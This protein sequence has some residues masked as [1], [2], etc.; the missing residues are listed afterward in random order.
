[1]KVKNGILGSLLAITMV[2]AMA[3]I[4]S[5]MPLLGAEAAYADDIPAIDTTVTENWVGTLEIN[6][7]GTYKFCGITH[8]NTNTDFDSAIHITDGAE[9]N[10]VFEGENHLT[11]N[12]S[13]P[14]LG[15]AGIQVDN[16]STVHIYGLDGS[17]LTVAGGG[18]GAG[19]GG[20]GYSHPGT[21]D[22]NKEPGKI[23]IHSGTITAIGG[24]KGAGI[25]SG[26]HSSGGDITILGGDIT[27]LG[28]G[29]GA[30][31]G[32]G[33]GTSGGDAT[34]AGAG[35]YN[36]GNITISGGKVRAAA[37]HM[38]FENFDRNDPETMYGAA[39]ADTFAA[40]I[41]G[42]YG[43]S[44]GTITI[45][46]NANVIALGSCGG[47]GIGT[48]RGTPKYVNFDAQHASCSVTIGGNAKVVA[49]ATADRRSGVVGDTGGAAIGLGRGVGIAG[50]PV[51]TIT[52]EGNADVYAYAAAGANGIGSSCAV[53]DF[54]KDP[55]SGEIVY[56]AN[57]SVAG[58]TIGPNTTVV[59]ICGS[60]KPAREAFDESVDPADLSL[61]ALH[62]DKTFFETAS[63]KD[64]VPFFQEDVF[65]ATINVCSTGS[66][67]VLTTIN[68]ESPIPTR[69]D[70]HIK[71]ADAAKSYYRIRDYQSD[72]G[73]NILLAKSLSA[74]GWK[75]GVGENDVTGLML[76]KYKIKYKLNGGKNSAS[77]PTQYSVL[78]S[79]V[80]LADPKRTYYKFGG[81]YDNKELTGS[82]VT[83]LP[84]GDIGDKQ[85]WAKWI[86]EG[87]L[88]TAKMTAKD[89]KNMTLEWSKTEGAEGYDIFFAR[90]KKNGKE[91]AFKKIKTIEGNKTFTLNKGDLKSGVSYKMYVKAFV[92]ENG[93]K[94]Y[95]YESPHMHAYA[96]GGTK[97]YTNAASVNVNKTKVKIKKGKTFKLKTEVVKL[98]SSKKLMPKAHV[99][100]VRYQ[101]T[102]KKIATVTKSGVIKGKKKGTCYVIAFAHNGVAKKVKVTV[103]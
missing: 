90:C 92:K 3:P 51:G 39:Y 79:A 9:V 52:I 64:G 33:Y 69:V 11:A 17:S 25:G 80:K 57:A 38:D 91:Q 28:T 96:G 99:S 95:V 61:T 66:S 49:M 34:A 6:Q 101:S 22:V 103:K 31:I 63:I 82:K 8:D 98:D 5:G 14:T 45:E 43:A 21:T 1:M 29:C 12:A 86:N 44:S 19:I 7:N 70:V 47:A 27:A 13:R 93:K 87:K 97:Y 60:P 74:K 30:G 83:S 58:L 2:F 89:G 94:K 59:A 15:G 42:G 26:Y 10:L 55:E 35:Y 71:Q 23:V 62:F 36:G 78:G 4:G 76:E 77:N 88:P 32:S 37:W 68:L 65:P 41:G 75:F 54:T 84:S 18:C 100:T 53:G 67:K 73:V 48:G 50:A 16:G 24:A 102:N 81:W 72:D 46:G 56:P 40:G 85:L 20:K